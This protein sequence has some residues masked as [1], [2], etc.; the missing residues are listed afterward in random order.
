MEL[1]K[2]DGGLVAFNESKKYIREKKNMKGRIVLTGISRCTC[3][4]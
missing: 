4:V 2:F 1:K 3:P